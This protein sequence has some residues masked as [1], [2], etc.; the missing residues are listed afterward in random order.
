MHDE[1]R[2]AAEAPAELDWRDESPGAERPVEAPPREEG[3]D[4]A[5]PAAADQPAGEASEDQ[6]RSW[7]PIRGLGGVGCLTMT[8]ATVVAIALLSTG[9]FFA[10]VAGILIFAVAIGVG[11]WLY[12]VAS[13]R[14]K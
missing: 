6:E 3:R 13:V 1:D 11:L 2:D 12:N 8:L 10:G 5:A 4:S 7:R 14:R 9:S